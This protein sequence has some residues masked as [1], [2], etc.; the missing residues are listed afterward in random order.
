MSNGLFEVD[1]ALFTNNSSCLLESSYSNLQKNFLLKQHTNK[2]MTSHIQWMTTLERY[3]EISG[4][5]AFNINVKI[6]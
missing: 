6:V 4:F 1:F 5:E 2:S 3:V